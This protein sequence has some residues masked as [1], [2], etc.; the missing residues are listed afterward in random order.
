M[1]PKTRKLRNLTIR[2]Y[3]GFVEPEELTRELGKADI[4]PHLGRGG[5]KIVSVGGR[6]LVGRKYLHGGL[7]RLITKDRFFSEKRCVAEAQTLNFLRGRGFPVVTPFATVAEKRIV[8]YRL[9]ILT[10]LE[11][12]SVTLLDYLN[13][14]G[15]KDRMSII[16]GFVHL[17]CRMQS[18]GVYHP[19]LHIANVLVALTGKLIFL[20]FDRAQRRILSRRDREAM[21][22]RLWRHIVKMERLG[23]LKLDDT[24]KNHLLKIYSRVG[25]ID[26]ESV[27]GRKARKGSY[28]HRVGGI[29]ESI[30]YRRRK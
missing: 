3:G 6:H 2:Y 30:V 25:G 1:R 23:R 29:L 28:V 5:I 15:H 24:E 11:Q 9:T 14:A 19:D 12:G 21:L 20:D 13:T 10:V 22:W 4:L 27:L 16:G 8:A 18:L 17:F 26:A 7:L